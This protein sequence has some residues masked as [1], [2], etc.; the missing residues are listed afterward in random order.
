MAG[1][2]NNWSHCFSCQEAERDEYWYSDA[3][4]LLFSS[5]MVLEMMSPI[6]T[7][8]LPTLIKVI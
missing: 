4:F 7:V 8:Y 3:F 5:T 2:G 1:A 6:V